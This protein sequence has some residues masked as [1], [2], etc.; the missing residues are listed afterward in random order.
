MKMSQIVRYL[1][2]LPVTLAALI[3]IPLVHAAALE[4][5]VV[6]AQKR[7]QS[8]Q[9]V[10]IAVTAFTADSL[11]TKGISDISKLSNYTPNVSFDAGTPFSG[12]DVVLSAYIRGIGQ[13][14]FV[15]PARTMSA[16]YRSACG[17]PTDV[18]PNFM[19]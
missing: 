4:E 14:D 1:C 11:Q 9:D 17:L 6:T 7:E 10:P 19:T 15:P 2:I 3:S 13:N 16:M 8:I 12:S 5:I 18:P